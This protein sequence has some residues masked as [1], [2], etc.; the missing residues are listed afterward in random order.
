M[1]LRGA[2]PSSCSALSPIRGIDA[3]PARPSVV[4]VKRKTPFSA[5]HDAVDAAAVE[6]EDARRRPRS[7]R[8]RS[9][10]CRGAARRAT[11]RR[12]SAPAS[13]SAVTITSSSPDSGRQPSSASAVAAATS[14]ATW[15]FMSSAPRPQTQPSFSSPDH[16]STRPVVGVGEHRVDVAEVGEP[17]AVARR[18]AGA[19]RGSA[20]RRRPTSSSHSKPAPSRRSFRN[21]CAACSFPGGLTVSKRISRCR[22]SVVRRSSSAGSGTPGRV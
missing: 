12:A 7:P 2:A 10:P 4:S 15:L 14:A 9:G 17:R 5:T 19:R 8:S 3:W 21:S 13:S 11:W 18:R 16:G 20:A 1:R 22:S 6:V